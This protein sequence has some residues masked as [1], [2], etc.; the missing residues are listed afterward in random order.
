MATNEDIEARRAKLRAL[1]SQKGFLSLAELTAEF[2]VSE[3]TIRRDLEILERAGVARRTHGGG[4]CVEY[5]T[6][7]R[8]GFADRQTTNFSAKRAIA[9]VIAEII[10]D[11]Q[12]VMIDGGTTCYQV[13]TELAG[14]DLS[15]VTNSVPIASLLF[16]EASG[17]VT[18]VGGYLYPRTG[19]ALGAT[20]VEQINKLHASLLVMSCAGLT[21]NGAFNINQMMADV[22]REMMRAAD[23]IVM[24]VDHSKLGVSSLAKICETRELDVIVTDSGLS[25]EQMKWLETLETKIVL[26]PIEQEN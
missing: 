2:A 7:Q 14:R 12:T 16:G 13:A 1:L 6:G 26:A 19:V 4:V 3:S 17:E 18:L 24:A 8:L 5:A 22:E 25:P 9:T 11:G 10:D 15:V 23:R 20:A 21:P